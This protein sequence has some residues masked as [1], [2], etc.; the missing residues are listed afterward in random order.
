M[1]I[2]DFYAAMFGAYI[3]SIAHENFW[4]LSEI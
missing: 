1:V 4:I 3:G 2:Y